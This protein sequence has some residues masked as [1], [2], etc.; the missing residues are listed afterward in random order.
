[1]SSGDNKLSLEDCLRELSKRLIR[2]NETTAGV[3]PGVK[4][5]SEWLQRLGGFC[6]KAREHSGLLCADVARRM[7]VSPNSI[8]MLDCGLANENELNESFLS[9]LFKAIGDPNLFGKFIKEFGPL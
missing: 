6:W 3:E 2:Y 4:G 9:S 5:S 7:R 1:M 8:V